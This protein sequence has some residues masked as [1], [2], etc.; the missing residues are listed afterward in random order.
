MTMTWRE[1]VTLAVDEAAEMIRDGA[2]QELTEEDLKV[3]RRAL[4]FPHGIPA[5]IRDT[6]AHVVAL[7]TEYLVNLSAA[8][9]F[10]DEEDHDQDRKAAL[11]QLRNP[12]DAAEFIVTHASL[13]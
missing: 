9:G 12:T 7:G 5:D 1:A 3:A 6:L 2:G 10:D 8:A 13:G 11:G 4:E